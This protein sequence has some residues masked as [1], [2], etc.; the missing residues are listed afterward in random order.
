MCVTKYYKIW[1][2]WYLGSFRQNKGFETYQ[3]TESQFIWT[4]I[5]GVPLE[6]VI[7]P[8]KHKILHKIKHKNFFCDAFYC[9]NVEMGETSNA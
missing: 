7:Q 4:N 6:K 5:E 8:F 9:S 2:V 1:V 3:W